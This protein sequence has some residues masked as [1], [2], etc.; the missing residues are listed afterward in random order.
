[1]EKKKIL[2][3]PAVELRLLV[4]PTRNS[5]CVIPATNIHSLIDYTQTHIWT[6]DQG[7]HAVAWLV[8]SGTDPVS[9]LILGGALFLRVERPEREADHSP[10]TSVKET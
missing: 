6:L 4:F 1:M 9:Y 10:A 5:D 2:N 8:G 3:L 7:E